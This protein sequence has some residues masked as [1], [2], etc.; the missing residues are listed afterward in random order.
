MMGKNL[1]MHV[2][3]LPGPDFLF[4]VIWY[5]PLWFF[6]VYLRQISLEKKFYK[7]KKTQLNFISTSTKSLLLMTPGVNCEH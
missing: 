2:S 4:V 7:K 6:F 1:K 3:H 5:H